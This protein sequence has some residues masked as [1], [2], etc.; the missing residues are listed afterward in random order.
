MCYKYYRGRSYRVFPMLYKSKIVLFLC[1]STLFCNSAF[2]IDSAIQESNQS[3]IKMNLT[4]TEKNKFKII[5]S[6]KVLNGNL[7]ENNE[8][9]IKKVIAIQKEEDSKDI[10]LLWDEAVVRNTV[11][12][13][14]LKKLSSPPEQRRIHSSLM[15][16]SISALINGAAI[17]PG[18]FGAD[19]FTSSAATAGGHLV[20]RSLTEKNMPKIIPLT[21]TELIHL[22]ELIDG[23]Q[24]KLIKNYY[25]YK[26]S[27]E[28]LRVCRQNLAIHSKNYSDAIKIHNN[29]SMIAT[30]ALYE[31][32]QLIELKLMQQGRLSRLE[33]E[34]LSGSDTVDKLSLTVPE[35]IKLDNEKPKELK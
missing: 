28:A 16:K 27:L 17:L 12:K 32:E 29:I 3:E 14:A 19:I 18:L 10:K 1:L 23:L 26:S 13:F 2:A 35:N 11:I 30:S 25:D 20:S 31:K 7:F 5:S 34:R 24:S 6:P 8:A 33:L 9:N 21:D 22:A 15:T 4:P